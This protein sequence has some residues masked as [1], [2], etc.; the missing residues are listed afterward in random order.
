MIASL[1]NDPRGLTVE[2]TRSSRTQSNIRADLDRGGLPM[3]GPRRTHGS[4]DGCPDS[5]NVSRT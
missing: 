4:Q 5:L 1:R 2:R 3:T